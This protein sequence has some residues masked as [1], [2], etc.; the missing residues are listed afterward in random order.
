MTGPK[1]SDP[2]GWYVTEHQNPT[3]WAPP[4]GTS[5]GGPGEFDDLISGWSIGNSIQTFTL[6]RQDPRTNP[7]AGSVN[8]TVQLTIEPGQTADYG[9]LGIWHGG[10]NGKIF[11][12]GNSPG[13]ADCSRKPPGYN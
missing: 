3:Y 13:W 2:S 8:A 7:G 11:I 6:S 1:S 10:S 4:N 12:Q 9:A 5:T